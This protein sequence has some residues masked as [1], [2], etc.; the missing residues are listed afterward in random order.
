MK[1]TL[2]AIALSLLAAGCASKPTTPTKGMSSSAAD[3]MQELESAA[4][5]LKRALT[6]LQIVTEGRGDVAKSRDAYLSDLAALDAQ[7]QTIRSRAV[8]LNQR[9]DAYLSEWVAKTSGISNPAMKE[10][11]EKRRTELMSEF[12][13]LGAKGRSLRQAYAPLHSALKDCG[14]FLESDTTP[15]A[16]TSLAPEYENIKKMEIEVSAAAAEFQAQVK[17]IEGMIAS[18]K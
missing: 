1:S 17:K 12:M 15:A 16:A 8:D 7:V 10:A 5:A 9:R 4:A 2:A 13:T 3:V 14:L 11:A 18:S 6:S